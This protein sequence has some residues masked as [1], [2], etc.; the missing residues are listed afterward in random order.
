[1]K[2]Y[3][4]SC[5]QAVFCDNTVCISCGQLLGFDPMLGIII[6]LKKTLDS[7]LVDGQGK[8][9]QL[10]A[11]RRLYQ[12]CNGIV[13]LDE[14]QGIDALC[15]TC[16]LNRTIPVVERPKNL[17]RWQRLE[18]AKRRMIAG[19]AAVDLQVGAGNQNAAGPMRF[20]FMEDKRSHPDVLEHF[21]STGHKN[22][23]ITI[24]LMEADDV[25]RVRQRELSGERQRTLLGHFRHEAGHY[26]YPQL[27]VDIDAFKNLFGDPFADYELA[28]RSYYDQGPSSGWGDRFISAYASSHPLEDWAECFAHVLHIQ[29]G[30]ETATAYGLIK[31]SIQVSTL[32][33]QLTSW[34]EFVISLNEINRSLGV[35]DP[36]PFV[37][38][39]IVSTKMNFVQESIR[40][41]VTNRA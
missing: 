22:G 27:V 16:Q 38:S 3:S 32:T 7:C 17:L 13:P 24:N 25:Q 30:L 10:C 33:E 26:F 18:A 19:L 1:M 9:Y 12:V 15:N 6:S 40:A 39:Q 37:V 29:D 4:C 36:Y 41:L 28:L 20:D 8:A 11:N 2:P 35:R 14:P 34:N 5:G 23:L 31:P 21:V